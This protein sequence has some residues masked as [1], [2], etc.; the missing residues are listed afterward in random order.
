MDWSYL[1]RCGC[2]PRERLFLPNGEGAFLFFSFL[3]RSAGK[4]RRNARFAFRVFRVPLA[5]PDGTLGLPFGSFAFRW[6]S[7]A[8]RSVCLSGPS[9]LHGQ[10]PRS[11]TPPLAHSSPGSSP[12]SN[13]PNPL[14][15]DGAI[16]GISR[17]IAVQ[18]IFSSRVCVL[19]S[20]A[21]R[22]KA[23]PGADGPWGPASRGSLARRRRTGMYVEERAAEG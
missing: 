2:F 10:S 20:G 12:G 4:A 7:Q 15:G 18:N 16:H 22:R 19:P 9:P 23:R 13:A 21:K 8:E 17:I 14:A 11:L 3:S 5:K 1:R 6:Q